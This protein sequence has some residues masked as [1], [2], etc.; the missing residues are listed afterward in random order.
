MQ[1]SWQGRYSLVLE[2]SQISCVS[3]Q[4]PGAIPVRSSHLRSSIKIDLLKNFAKFTEKH[5]CQSLFFN[6]VTGLGPA[7][8]LKRGSGV[9]VFL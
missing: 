5:L 3:H 2:K 4:G 1:R 8:L 6:K 9:G 7:T